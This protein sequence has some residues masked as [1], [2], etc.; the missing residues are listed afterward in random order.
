MRCLREWLLLS[1]EVAK[2]QD[3]LDSCCMLVEHRVWQM[4]RR[5]SLSRDRHYYIA[6]LDPIVQKIQLQCNIEEPDRDVQRRIQ[7]SCEA[8]EV[9]T[10]IDSGLRNLG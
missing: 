1:Q 2:Y 9:A 8:K 4:A 7:F 3:S 10:Q 5:Q 6:I